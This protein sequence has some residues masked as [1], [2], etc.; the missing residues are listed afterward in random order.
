MARTEAQMKWDRLVLSRDSEVHDYGGPEVMP[1]RFAIIVE[2]SLESVHRIAREKDIF[3]TS[4]ILSIGLKDILKRYIG[5]REE[6]DMKLVI[7]AIAPM[8]TKQETRRPTC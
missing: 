6:T 3:M 8:G 1:L 7:S 2:T 5:L 4:L